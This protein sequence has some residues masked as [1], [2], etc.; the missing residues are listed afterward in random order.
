MVEIAA[1]APA[2]FG[3]E[4]GLV[5]PVEDDPE[6]FGANP[7]M[8]DVDVCAAIVPMPDATTQIPR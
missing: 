3:H 7:V 4:A 5:S 6:I 8:I 2:G 1:I